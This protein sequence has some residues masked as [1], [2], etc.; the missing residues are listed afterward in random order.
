M[1]IL[2]KQT[3]TVVTASLL[4]FTAAGTWAAKQAGG[5]GG[6]MQRGIDLAQQKQYDAAIAEFTKA[7]E[8]NPKDPRGYVNRGIAYRASGKT[9]EAAG[10]G[11]TATIRYQTSVADFAK[12]VQLAPGDQEAYVQL[13]TT[14]ILQRDFEGAMADLDKAI[15]LKPNDGAAY[16][17]RGFARLRGKDYENAVADLSKAI[18]LKADP[19]AYRWR[20]EAY[21]DSKRYELAVADYTAIL[22]KSDSNSSDQARLETADMLAKRGYIYAL[23]Q[24]YQN[25]I[26]DYEAALRLNPK[27]IDTPQRL[28]YA[29]SMLKLQ[30]APPPTATPAP[31]PKKPGLIT[32]LNVGIAI[33]VLIIIAIIWRLVTRGKTEETSGRIR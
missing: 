29:Q 32:P 20:A 30:N 8:A 9:A 15:S 13:G 14:K 25:A 27:D 22:S 21:R 12:A 19:E 17:V 1:N 31:T 3:I 18:D 2:N 28:Q 33:A 26:N 11:G 24:Q 6:H 5:G 7:I 16:K 23:M 10:D 4:W